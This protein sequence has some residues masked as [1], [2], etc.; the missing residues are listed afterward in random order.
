DPSGTFL[1]IMWPATGLMVSGGLTS[2]ALKWRAIS[3]A[4]AGLGHSGASAADGAA[5]E[6]NLS[7][8]VVLI[9]AAVLVVALRVLQWLFFAVPVWLTLAGIVCA[10][11]L[12]LAGIRV[13]GETNWAPITSMA[14]VSQ[15][16]F[17]LLA[18]GSLTVNMIGSGLCATIP[19]NG[20]H[21]MQNYRA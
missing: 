16:V 1:W 19:A 11:P 20:E 2:L 5:A 15:A 9:S 8:P 13:L 6:D 14:N 17:A 4:F 12:S 7:R 10:V 18:P 21:L 3:R